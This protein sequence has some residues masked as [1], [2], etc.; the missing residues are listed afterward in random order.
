MVVAWSGWLFML[1]CA[2]A[3][4]FLSPA[5]IAQPTVL[6]GIQLIDQDRQPLQ[7][8]RL[9]DR[10]VL[11]NFVFTACSAVCPLQTRQI[12]QVQQALPAGVAGQVHFLSVSIDPLNDTPEALRGFAQRT[13]ADLRRWSFATGSPSEVERLVARMD[14][15]RDARGRAPPAVDPA[16]HTT[17]LILFDRHGRAVQRY[18]G[19]PVD[20]AR[21][22]REIQQV[23]LSNVTSPPTTPDPNKTR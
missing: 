20:Q 3:T 18:R 7:A 2:A 16:E 14:P 13:G 8:E 21:L 19:V 10:T 6:D 1:L 15:R 22:V 11:L 23:V 9:R 17:S 4:G 12:A 5:A